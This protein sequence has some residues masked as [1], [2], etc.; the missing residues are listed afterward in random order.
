[1][2]R[3]VKL[4][5]DSDATQPGVLDHHLYVTGCVH[6]G[7]GIEGSLGEHGRSLSLSQMLRE[8]S[9][10]P[11]L[12]ATRQSGWVTCLLSSGKVELS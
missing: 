11:R 6:V 10:R 8:G 1:M 3:S 4:C 9:A 5:D 7:H 12:G 2:P